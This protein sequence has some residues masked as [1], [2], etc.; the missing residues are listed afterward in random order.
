VR[1]AAALI[2][3]NE[4]LSGKTVDT[5]SPY[6]A[7]ELRELG[8]DLRRIWVVPDERAEIVEG[9]R[10]LAP[11]YDLVFT[12]GGVGPTHD[13]VTLE[14]IAEALGRPL[15][16]NP[17]MARLIARYHDVDGNPHA[18][19]MADL[20][21]GAKLVYAEELRVPVVEVENLYVLPGVPSIFE[22][23]VRALRER[24]RE[25]PFHLRQVLVG[26]GEVEIAQT[27]VEV[28]H[29]HAGLLLGSYPEMVASGWRVKLTLESKDRELVERALADL[30]E[31]LPAGSVL[32][33]G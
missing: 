9:V 25:A 24:F 20:P 32:G 26:A 29:R 1:T 22:R 7:R 14:A 27:L 18:L 10:A 23:K 21:R 16:R 3:G 33:R 17:E 5:N 11:R 4:I 2:I 12:S 13:D 8:V 19:R 6:L 15:E 31:R 30:L 28:V